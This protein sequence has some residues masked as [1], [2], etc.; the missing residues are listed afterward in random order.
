MVTHGLRLAR[1]DTV[2]NPPGIVV[3]TKAIV[4]EIS[5]LWLL[6]NCG[7]RP[8]DPGLSKPFEVRRRRGENPEE[9]LPHRDQLLPDV[10]C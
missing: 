5:R 10:A 9:K 3:Y 2:Q 4:V 6:A 8:K 7:L 1:V